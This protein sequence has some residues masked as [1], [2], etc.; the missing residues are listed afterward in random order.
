ML[1][2]LLYLGTKVVDAC[3]VHNTLQR[4]L[5]FCVELF[6]YL[7][8]F[9]SLSQFLE[10]KFDIQEALIK[11]QITGDILQHGLLV[12]DI[13]Y[14]LR[15]IVS[16]IHFF[17]SSPAFLPSANHQLENSLLCPLPAHQEKG[18]QWSLGLASM[19]FSAAHCLSVSSSVKCKG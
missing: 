5:C 14:L 10:S 2:L 13:L 17:C 11:P 15:F 16:L 19:S 7:S 3:P 9:P 1:K 6:S 4:S 8:L 18:P 12:S